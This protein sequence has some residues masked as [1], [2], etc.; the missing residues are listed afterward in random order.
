MDKFLDIYNLPRL[1][2]DD[3]ESLNRLITS[4]EIESVINNLPTKQSPG[5][6]DFTSEFYKLL[7]K[8]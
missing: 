3:A 6:D 5:P 4:Q 1:S 7:K 8:S 2:Q